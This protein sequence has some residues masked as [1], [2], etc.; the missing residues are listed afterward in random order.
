MSYFALLW[1]ARTIEKYRLNYEQEKI[2]SIRISNKN[3]P[4]QTLSQRWRHFR[5]DAHKRVSKTFQKWYP[6][7]SSLS[8]LFLYLN[9]D[10]KFPSIVLKS[11]FGVISGSFLTYLCFMFLVFQLSLTRVHATI[12]SGIIGVLLTLG[13]AFSSR[14]RCLIFL[15]LPHF[16]SRVGRYTL[17]CYALVL[18][19]TGPATNTLKNLEVLTESM[20]CGQEQVKASVN[21]VNLLATKPLNAL[22]DSIKMM[23]GRLKTVY[24]KLKSTLL[25]INKLIL[26]VSHVIETGCLWLDS[27]LTLCNKKLG[28]PL[29]KC[30]TSLRSC[31][32]RRVKTFDFNNTKL[33]DAE[34]TMQTIVDSNRNYNTICVLTPCANRN[35]VPVVKKRLNTLMGRVSHMLKMHV[36]V[37]HSYYF[38]NDTSSPSQ[39]AAGLVTELRRRADPLLAWLAWSSCVTSL[40]LLLIIFRAKNYQHMFETKSRFD[41]HYITKDIRVLDLKRLREGRETI[42][43]LNRRERLKYVTITSFRLMA[44]EKAYLNRSV[45]SMAVTTFKLLIHVVAD[46]SLYWVL[47]TILFY[48]KLQTPIQ[49]DLPNAGVQWSLPRWA[50]VSC[51]PKPRQPDFKRYMQIGVLILLLW[52]FA[53]LEPYGL[54]LRHVIMS[55]YQPERAK[56][57]ATWLYNNILRDQSFMKFA[58]RKLHRSYKYRTGERLTFRRWLNDH[59]PCIWLRS[60]LGVSP[61]QP[62][63]LLCGTIDHKRRPDT[64]LIR[65]DSDDWDKTVLNRARNAYKVYF[66]QVVKLLTA[67]DAFAIHVSGDIGELCTICPR[68][69]RLWDLSDV[70]LEK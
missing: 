66:F 11:I 16:F 37:R 68:S 17:T 38:S 4:N 50:P 18:I 20:A 35:V 42:L 30:M 44:A 56:V 10:Y 54:R 21:H 25:K 57:R 13:L 33:C 65:L 60:F 59:I 58:R 29:I 28:T 46:Y 69:R 53:M 52:L 12:L 55:H 26:S 43:P 63:C 70:S 2:N 64:Q 19:L 62:H 45:V 41:N 1:K 32:D 5:Y 24:V 47:A 48:G 36:H 40:F 9:T 8:N 31:I 61:N 15:L 22:K 3:I 6:E 51:L 14:V 34:E 67:Q 39:V 27:L 49:L 7:G 23:I